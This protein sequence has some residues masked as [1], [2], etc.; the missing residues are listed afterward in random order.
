MKKSILMFSLILLSY[1]YAGSQTNDDCLMCHSDPEMSLERGHKKI[2]LWVDNSKF[3]FSAHKGLKC[4]ACHKGFNIDDIPHKAK[5]EPVDCKS[6]HTNVETKHTFHPWMASAPLKDNCKQCHGYHSVTPPKS[7]YS[8]VGGMNS[9]EKCGGCHKDVKEEFMKSEHYKVLQ[10]KATP[11]SPDCNYCH[12]N[13][14]TKGWIKNYKQRKDN[15]NNVC[16]ECHK[17]DTHNPEV[18]K[19]VSN[20]ESRHAKLR[21]SGKEHAAVCTDCHGFHNIKKS[22]DFEARLNV[23]NSS[24]SCG[25]CHIH[26]AQEYQNSIHGLAQM[27]GNMAAAGCVSCHFE[28]SKNKKNQL[29]D[30]IFNDN[31]LNRDFAENGKMTNCIA[32]H[33]NDSLISTGNFKNLKSSHKWLPFLKKH[34]EKV[35]CYDCHSSFTEPYLS[36]NILPIEKSL[37]SCNDCHNKSKELKSI[38][39]NYEKGKTVDKEGIISGNINRNENFVGLARNVI[40]DYLS[41]IILGGLIFGLLIHSYVRWYFK[42]GQVK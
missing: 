29:S 40:L 5:I 31:Q 11:N 28:H 7:M 36:H 22:E 21:K 37:K 18:L 4:L 14:I 38:L 33:T 2:S 10:N 27:K 25:K 26:I 19:K 24:S 6:C 30:K 8:T 23:K 3:A 1:M 12:R 17:S 41:L 42:K 13:P 16:I 20:D 39:F 32:C 9:V 34:F 35:S 15:Q